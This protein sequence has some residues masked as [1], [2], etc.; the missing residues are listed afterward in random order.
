MKITV[1]A[2]ASATKDLQGEKTIE[3]VIQEGSNLLFLLEFIGLSRSH[4]YVY[5]VN[6]K[7][8]LPENLR[9]TILY[10]RDIVKII[11]IVSGG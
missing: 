8:A 3:V 7:I 4:P 10:D 2:V 11:P 5:S 9:N 1:V 6:E